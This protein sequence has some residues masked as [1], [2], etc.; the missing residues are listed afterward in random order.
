MMGYA[1]SPEVPPPDK[2]RHIRTRSIVGVE[3]VEL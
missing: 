2:D 1:L 3:V